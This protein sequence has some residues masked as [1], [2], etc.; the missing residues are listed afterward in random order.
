MSKKLSLHR[1]QQV[2]GPGFAIFLLAYFV[3]HI[4][5]GE[6]G[7]LSWMRLQQK[8]VD[9]Q[10][11]LE[12]TQVEHDTLEHRVYL[13]RPDSLDLDMLE[14]RA[15]QVLNLASSKDELICLDKDIIPKNIK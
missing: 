1:F 13:L 12:D 5:Q 14:E 6:R 8:I 10:K 3:Y 11:I 2:L 9:A 7:I 15:R 4:I